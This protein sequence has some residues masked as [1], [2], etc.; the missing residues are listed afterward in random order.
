MPQLSPLFFATPPYALMPLSRAAFHASAPCDIVTRVSCLF[1]HGAISFALIADVMLMPLRCLRLPFR[2][3]TLSLIAT[4]H[5]PLAFATLI[6]RR[7]RYSLMSFF[8][9]PH[10]TPPCA[11]LPAR[12]ALADAV[13]R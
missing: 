6:E 8:A 11:M 7:A 9:M 2:H 5:A 1:C 4:S 12:A 3:D 10:A 13:C